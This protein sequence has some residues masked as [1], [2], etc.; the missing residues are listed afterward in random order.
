MKPLRFFRLGGA[1]RSWRYRH[2]Y[3]AA[4]DGA[5]ARVDRDTEID[6]LAKH[7]KKTTKGWIGKDKI[8]GALQVV[9][10][11]FGCGI[12]QVVKHYES[13]ASTDARTFENFPPGSRTPT[14]AC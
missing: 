7:V 2:D 6:V 10:A 8:R 5:D 12:Y 1:V 4:S 14:L 13:T 11:G 9:M 3:P